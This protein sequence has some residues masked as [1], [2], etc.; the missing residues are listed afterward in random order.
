MAGRCLAFVCVVLLCVSI[1]RSMRGFAVAPSYT[2][3]AAAFVVVHGQHCCY[4]SAMAAMPLR[5]VEPTLERALLL[6]RVGCGGSY[7]RCS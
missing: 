5:V 6:L 2:R 7:Y 3:G 1:T 4:S